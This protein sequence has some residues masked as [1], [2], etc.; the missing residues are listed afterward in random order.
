[1][2]RRK[3]RSA[4]AKESACRGER[5]ETLLRKE[6]KRATKGLVLR[7]ERSHIARRKEPFRNTLIIKTLRDRNPTIAPRFP[8]RPF[9]V[10][11]AKVRTTAVGNAHGRTVV[12]RSTRK[13]DSRCV[14]PPQRF[15]SL[16]E[17]SHSVAAD[18]AYL[19]AIFFPLTMYMPAGRL[20]RVLA[21]LV[22][23]MRLPAME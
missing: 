11:I 12:C 19:T 6:P 17:G 13:G 8:L 20:R 15:L 4:T 1:M 3:N 2:P 7:D 23:V 9:V 10:L 18:G 5:T 22:V 21:S 14:E 16:S